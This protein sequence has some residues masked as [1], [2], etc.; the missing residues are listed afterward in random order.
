M[1]VPITDTP[2]L[3]TAPTFS[4]DQPPHRNPPYDHHLPARYCL[5]TL[6]ILLS[7]HHVFVLHFLHE[8]KS[9]SKGIQSLEW[10]HVMNEELAAYHHTYT[11]HILLYDPGKEKTGIC[12]KSFP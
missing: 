3:M 4:D 1:D 8:P 6:H 10:Q 11:C 2:L 5:L 7:S 12:G 9:Y